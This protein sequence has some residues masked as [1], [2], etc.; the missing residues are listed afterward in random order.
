MANPSE[1]QWWVLHLPG[2]Y[3]S[4]YSNVKPTGTLAGHFTSDSDG[5][6]VRILADYEVVYGPCSGSEAKE[7]MT[8][9]GPDDTIKCFACGH[10]Y[11]TN[12]C[13]WCEIETDEDNPDVYEMPICPH[14]GIGRE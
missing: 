4:V 11:S 8:D 6:D 7:Y 2:E 3:V 12:A 5:I 9:V 13:A 10:L 1:W 14:C